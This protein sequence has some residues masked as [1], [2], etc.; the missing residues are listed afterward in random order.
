MNSR[1]VQ[2]EGIGQSEITMLNLTTTVAAILGRPITQADL[3]AGRDAVAIAGN[4][5]VALCT[6]TRNLFGKAV[7]VSE[8][9]TAKGVPEHVTVQVKGNMILNGTTTL[10]TVASQAIIC[11]GGKVADITGTTAIVT[12]GIGK[13]RNPDV[14]NVSDTDR[15]DVML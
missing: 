12:G 13:Y 4:N 14:I 9:L 1:I 10:P 11:R 8:K 6:T 7:A 15:I 3:D 2:N 5:Q